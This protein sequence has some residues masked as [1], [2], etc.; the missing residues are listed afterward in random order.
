VEGT[1]KYAYSHAL[2]RE[3]SQWPVV[4]DVSK[5]FDSRDKLT[6]DRTPKISLTNWKRPLLPQECFFGRAYFKIDVRKLT[7][8]TVCSYIFHGALS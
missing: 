6:G 8:A 2:Y 4:I 5:P 3:T 7:A 1:V